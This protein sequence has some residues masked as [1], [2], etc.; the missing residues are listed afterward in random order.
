MKEYTIHYK[1]GLAQGLRAT[2]NNPK[3]T[4]ALTKA[5]GVIQKAGQLFNLEELEGFDIS[6][7]EACTFP[8]PQIF[9]LRTWTIICTPT[10][11][12]TYDGTTLT[13]AFTATEGSTWTVGDFYDYLVMS[14]GLE[15]IVL[16]PET[17][18]WSLFLDCLVPYCLCL[19]D[20][21][22]QLFVGGPEVAISAGWLG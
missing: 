18:D 5:Q 3:N 21:N 9:Q 13:L 8:F 7:I 16:D 1:T 6:T 12:Y 10:K 4:G 2:E 19:T 15:L 11:I 17:G 20:L 14:N 22:G